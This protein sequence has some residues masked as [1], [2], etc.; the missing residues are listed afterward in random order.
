MTLKIAHYTRPDQ[1]EPLLPEFRLEEFRQRTRLLTQASYR[2]SSAAHP[3]TIASLRELVR[4]MNSYYSNRIEGQGTHPKNIERA[5]A[6]DFSAQPE[7]ARLQRL[8]LAHIEAEKS[9]EALV[10]E[11]ESPLASAFLRE[12]HRALYGRL[13]EED[14][15][16][17]DG[18]VIVPGAW[19]ESQVM[20]GRHEPPLW[21]ALPAFLKRMDQVYTRSQSPD[22]LLLQVAAAHHRAAWVHPFPD[23]NGRAVRLQT[24]CALFPLSAGLWSMNRGLARQR[25]RYYALLDAADGPRQGDLD[26]RGNLSEKALWAWCEWFISVAEDQV[27]FM[28]RMLQLDQMKAR[29]TAWVAYHAQF[30]KGIR[31]EAILPL[32]HVFLAGTVPRG[33]F[34]QMTGLAERTARTLLSRLLASG[35]LRSPSH[36]APVQFGFPLEALQFLLPD[37]YPEAAT[38]AP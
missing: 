24:H 21:S 1:F 28:T 27:A 13:S 5:L 17:P 32:Y 9:L 16:P 11:G 23:G 31:A 15:T 4:A 30:G 33:E 19:R 38:Q 37:L 2:L 22:D 36:V 6:Q 7:V 26:G 20:V 29:I 8:A 12:A 34:L 14:R 25:E 10:T 3:A 35:L 18:P